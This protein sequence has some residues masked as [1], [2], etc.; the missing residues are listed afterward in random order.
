MTRALFVAALLLGVAAAAVQEEDCQ[1]GEA[2]EVGLLQS[3][4]QKHIRTDTSSESSGGMCCVGGS[5]CNATGMESCVVLSE[6]TDEE[7]CTAKTGPECQIPE[8]YVEYGWVSADSEVY[9]CPEG[10]YPAPTPPPPP[11]PYTGP[12]WTPGSKMC[13]IGVCTCGPTYGQEFC[14]EP[15]HES[16]LEPDGPSQFCPNGLKATKMTQFCH[17]SED[18]CIQCNGHYC[19][20]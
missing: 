4:S 6:C 13:Y 20:R 2:E 8:R 15:C 7:S 12:T 17:A 1:A 19:D 14:S 5:G 10:S 11:T 18:N 3:R 16:K 9:W